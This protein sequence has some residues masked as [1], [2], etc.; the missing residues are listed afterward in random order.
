GVQTKSLELSAAVAARGEVGEGLVAR[1][2]L[3]PGRYDLRAAVADEFSGLTGTV[4]SFV[5][6]PAFAHGPLTASGVLLHRAHPPVMPANPLADVVPFVPTVARAFQRTEDVRAFVRFYQSGPPRSSS[7]RARV[8]DALGGSVFDRRTE[9]GAGT[10]IA[11]TA[12]FD[13]P[14]PLTELVPGDYLLR[15]ETS[16]GEAIVERDVRFSVVR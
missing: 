16:I 12:D 4:F 14:L 1:L 8:I 3:P 9:L 7:V 15:I 10:F 2:N 11:G 13:L 6:V 5:D